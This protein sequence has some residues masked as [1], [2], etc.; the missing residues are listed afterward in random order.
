MC[1]SN[2]LVSLLPVL[3]DHNTNVC[4]RFFV[5]GK[6]NHKDDIVVS[7]NI[8][9]FLASVSDETTLKWVPAEV[10][11]NTVIDICLVNGES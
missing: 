9:M 6:L 3:I 8:I 5:P 1:E 7:F 10:L 2:T 4:F 11:I